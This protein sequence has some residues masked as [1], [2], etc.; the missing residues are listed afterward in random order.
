MSRPLAT[1]HVGFG[2]TWQTE[3]ADIDWTDVT[4]RVMDRRQAVTCGRGSNSSKEGPDTGDLQ[5]VLRNSDREL[6]P[7]NTAG[8]LFGQL[9]P[10]VPVKIEAQSVEPLHWGAE[11]L[12]WDAEP[13]VW[14]S[15]IY[16]VWRGTVKAWP[17]RYDRGNKIAYVPIEAYDGFDKLARAKTAR[18]VLEAEI[19]AD[20]PV[21]Y[22]KLDEQSGRIMVDTSGSG[23]HGIYDNATLGEDPLILDD[24]GA[25]IFC[26]HVGDN[27]GQYKGGNLPTA[28]PVTLEAWV[29]LDRD[30]AEKHTIL[31]AQ[32]DT[33][34]GSSLG[35][36]VETS[37]LGSP[38]GELVVDFRGLG[39]FYKV[40]GHTRI[41]DGEVHHVAMTMASTAA[42][43]I[44]LYVDGVLQTKTVISGTTGGTWSGHHIWCIG[45]VAAS[46]LFDFGLEGWIDE[47]AIYDQALSATRILDHY[48]AGADA[49][50]GQ[51]SDARID[52]M[53]DQIGWPSDLR[54]LE[55]GRSQL[56]PATF[57][58]G[59][60]AL[61]YLRLIARTEDGTLYVTADGK[62]RLLDRYW[63]YLDPAATVPQIVLTDDGTGIGVATF[64]LDPDDEE[65][66]VNVA[67]Y[68]RRGGA[69]QIAVDQTSTETFGEAELQLTD[70]LHQSDAETAALAQWTVSTRGLPVP[71]VRSAL[72]RVHKAPSADQLALLAL[73]IGHRVTCI[74]TPQG[75]GTPFTIDCIV[76]GIR[77]E[78]TAVEWLTELYLAPA[79]DVTVELFTLGTSELGGTDILA[80]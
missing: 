12:L 8:D 23:C 77:H 52:W 35:M 51:R 20:D 62:I 55:T 28:A 15:A 13:L 76:A 19:L 49:F 79:P 56:G 2:S 37:A 25:S 10:G 7:L 53:L 33:A 57:E 74:R 70:F 78:I 26:A 14:T 3:D 71:R 16:P 17:Q 1:V 65:L 9:R 30:L 59:D 68:T 63:R 6:D 46:S 72:I 18:T 29:R 60:K 24:T 47:V 36:L 40:R 50:T 64:E 11:P 39:G 31:V 67:R 69:Q 41:D 58:P 73:D 45:N 5:L 42:A 21:A 34:F 44:K 80:Y 32:R 48:D 75:V 54:D 38:D 43:D 61:E 66:L 27:R 4:D 22:W